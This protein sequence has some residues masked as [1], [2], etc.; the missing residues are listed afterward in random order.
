[1]MNNFEKLLPGVKQNI[2]LSDYSTFQIGGLASYFFKVVNKEDLIKAL[3]AAEASGLPFFIL[4][5][6]SNVLFPNEGYKGL[7]IKISNRDIKLKDNYLLVQAG[8]PLAEVLK[9]TKESG[10]TG[11][12]WSAGIYGTLGGAIRGN[13]G[14]FGKSMADVVKKVQVFDYKDKKIKE[15]LNKDCQFKYRESVFKKNNNLII[16]EALLEFKKGNKDL[17]EQTINKNLAY[18]KEHQPL[19][20]PC[21]G[22][23]FKN[24]EIKK[25][26]EDLFKNF[27]RLKEFKKSSFI[28]AGVLIE[29][30][31]LKG[32]RIGDAKFS[33][34]HANMIVN[35]HRA[36]SQEVLRLIEMAKERVKSF[37]G[38]ELEEEIVILK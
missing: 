22:S 27:G 8:V 31:G 34:K 5:G 36:K 32:K 37:F 15:F 30:I 21:A 1:M 11:F 12:E 3:R 2:R 23:I 7:I 10:L 19:N 17:I 29:E 38:L 13:A 20:Y 4:G 6:G 35:L 28:P 33:E 16:L 14:S 25:G 26:D 18:K 9:K 24:Y